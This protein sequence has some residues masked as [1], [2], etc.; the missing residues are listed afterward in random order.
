MH[1]VEAL[2]ALRQRMDATMLDLTPT[3]TLDPD[4][5]PTMLDLTPTLTLR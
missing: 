3:L 4:P 1:L 5:D 2:G